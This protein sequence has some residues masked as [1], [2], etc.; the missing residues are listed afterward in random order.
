MKFSTD[1]KLNTCFEKEKIIKLI[2]KDCI[3]RSRLRIKNKFSQ[4]PCLFI[5]YLCL[6]I[7]MLISS[8][9]HFQVILTDET[10]SEDD[11]KITIWYLQDLGKQY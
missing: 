7:I 2:L 6:L 11:N 10:R 9:R 4:L 3:K 5:I 8:E 1:Y